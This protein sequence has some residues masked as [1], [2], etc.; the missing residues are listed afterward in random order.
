MFDS[1]EIVVSL[2]GVLGTIGGVILG[3]HLN[4]RGTISTAL[5]MAKMEREKHFHSRIWDMRRVS[6]SVILS[7]LNDAG[8]YSGWID[9]GYNSG[10]QH[11][12][13]YHNS[14]ACEMNES[15]LREVWRECKMEF[16]ASHLVI[17]ENFV[18]EFR[19]LLNSL[20]EIGEFALPPEV[21]E[22]RSERFRSA[23][24]KLLSMTLDEFAPSR[25]NELLNDYHMVLKK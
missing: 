6:Y 4:K 19:N 24:D 5:L 25:R 12:E 20:S 13:I 10:Q 3:T 18:T 14:E 7:K 23:Y 17:S 16:E 2:I 9:E 21:A 11:P 15:K 8:R 1:V 22:Q